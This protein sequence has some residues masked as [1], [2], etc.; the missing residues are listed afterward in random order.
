M[1]LLIGIDSQFGNVDMLSYI[2][3][4]FKPTY[5]GK[6]IREEVVKLILCAGL[7]LVGL[8]FSSRMGFEILSFVNSYIIVIP[9]GF[10]NFINYYVFCI[11]KRQGRLR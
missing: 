2:I 6:P 5:K 1:L 10:I 9:L 3:L 11:I 8:I 7:A 4:D